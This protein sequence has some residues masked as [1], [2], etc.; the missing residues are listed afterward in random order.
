M[1]PFSPFTVY[2][3]RCTCR[4]DGDAVP[5]SR[6][7]TLFFL[8]NAFPAIATQLLKRRPLLHSSSYCIC[9]PIKYSFPYIQVCTT[10]QGWHSSK[11][12]PFKVPSVFL[13]AFHSDVVHQPKVAV[14]QLQLCCYFMFTHTT[15]R[16][17]TAQGKTVSRKHNMMLSC[18]IF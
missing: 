1:F 10:N 16:Y 9:H 7:C 5:V 15:L 8:L 18:R 4:N 13:E 2:C 12:T 3:E 6:R 17:V 14:C 11:L